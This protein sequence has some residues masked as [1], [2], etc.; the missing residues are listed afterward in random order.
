M[1]PPTARAHQARAAPV[2]C[3]TRG[4]LAA[5]AAEPRP[6][7]DGRRVEVDRL[8]PDDRA[9]DVLFLPRDVEAPLRAGEVR[10]AML[11]G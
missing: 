9:E 6:A 3:S 10:V 7:V 8:D 5:G 11:P 2:P 1:T 4:E